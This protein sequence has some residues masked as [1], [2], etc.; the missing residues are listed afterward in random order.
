[1]EG[2][3]IAFDEESHVKKIPKE[4]GSI[5]KILDYWDYASKKLLNS[6]FL[7]RVKNFK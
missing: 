7:K 3:I 2:V 1:M 5:E 4:P 6:T